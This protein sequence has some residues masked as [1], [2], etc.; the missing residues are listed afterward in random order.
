MPRGKREL[1]I[2]DVHAHI[3]P[4]ADDGAESLEESRRM[5]EIAYRQGIRQIIA[6]PHYRRGQ[7]TERLRA[8]AGELQRE[9]WNVDPCCRIYLGQELMDSED[10][11]ED[12]KT[13]RA[14]TMG[15]S[16]YVLI[17]FHTN[18]SFSHIYQRLRQLEAAGY[19]PVVA[20]VERYGCLRAEGRVREL[21]ETGSCIQMNY[22]SLEG[23]V[24]NKEVR[25]CRRQ[26]MEG[27]VHLLGTDMHHAERRSPDIEKALGWL[28]GHC[29]RGRL[30]RMLKKNPEYILMKKDGMGR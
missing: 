9:A 13:G 18:A 28:K 14:L 3:L 12:L 23:S 26:V 2:I 25:W 15:G 21:I 4:G 30:H 5:L 29:P 17:E 6:T 24:F 1:E 19:L 27:N 10:L 22:S 16:R 8:L 11:I 7:D 20:H